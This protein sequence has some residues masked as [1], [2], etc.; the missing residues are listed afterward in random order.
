MPAGGLA[1]PVEDPE[2]PALRDARRPDLMLATLARVAGLPAAD[3][4]DAALTSE[5][6]SHKV[7]QRC[8]IRYVVTSERL[9]TGS[10][11]VIAKLYRRQV[12]AARI[13]S[14]MAALRTEAFAG[15]DVSTIP[16]SLGVVPE[17]GMALQEDLDGDDLRHPLAAGTAETPLS[18]TARWLADLHRARPV[19]GLKGK[20]RAHELDKVD[21]AC[22][23]VAPHLSSHQRARVQRMRDHLHLLDDGRDGRASTMIH[24]DFYYAHV[25]WRPDRIGVIDFDSL[26]IGDPALDVGHFL[27]HLEALGYRR[28]V[29]PDRFADAGARFLE[30]Y[31]DSGPADVRPSLTFFRSYTHLK[32]ASI[33]VA[34]QSGDWRRRVADYADLAVRSAGLRTP[35][36]RELV[37]SR[38]R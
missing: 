2:L 21:R 19:S 17:L 29:D 1:G 33:E 4:P 6:L 18:L 27:A 23:V 38:H 26:S 30:C 10:R 37:T 35:M 13:H 28:A 9:A 8:T 36:A 32:L 31:L 7:A 34:R 11:A 20:S 22:V 15:E 16:Q 14:F 24:R 25:L 12:L 3:L 5:V